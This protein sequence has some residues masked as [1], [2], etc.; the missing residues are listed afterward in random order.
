MTTQSTMTPESEIDSYLPVFAEK[1][2]TLEAGIIYA[3]LAH[4]DTEITRLN[5]AELTQKH[6]PPAAIFA[7]EAHRLHAE[8]VIEILKSSADWTDCRI[9]G[10]EQAA[11]QVRCPMLLYRQLFYIAGSWPGTIFLAHAWHLNRLHGDWF[12]FTERECKRKLL[13]SRSQ[14]LQSR[15]QLTESG[16]LEEWRTGFPARLYYRINT[17]KLLEHVNRFD[18]EHAARVKATR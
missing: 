15:I 13:L 7:S 8:G 16:V 18:Q 4:S 12:L 14:Y 9:K 3:I 5:Y 11:N 6:G 1:F 2:G 17:D 10:G